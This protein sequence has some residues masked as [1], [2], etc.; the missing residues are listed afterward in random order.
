MNGRLGEKSILTQ[1]T[2]TDFTTYQYPNNNNRR[3][4]GFDKPLLDYKAEDAY[5]AKSASPS[6]FGHSGYT[7]TFVW[8]DPE[9]DII[10]VF[11]SNRVFP[12][13]SH[14]N[15]YHLNIRPDL[16]QACYDFLL[17]LNSE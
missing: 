16:H 4:L 12:S 13:R 1:K 2:I 3:G 7:G 17:K 15:L 8:A 11:L 6:S 14:R 5:I 10:I 9:A